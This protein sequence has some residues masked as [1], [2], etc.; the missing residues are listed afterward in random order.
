MSEDNGNGGAA[1]ATG[2]GDGAGT[3]AQP[4]LIV[5]AQYIKDFSFEAPGTP[6]VFS[7]MQQAQPDISVNVDVQARALE[8][9]V[10][11]VVLNVRADCKVGETQ[12]FLVEL[13]YGG[14]FTLNVAQDNVHPVLLI[15]C[16]RLLFPFAR[17][18]LATTTVNGGF[19]PLMLGPIDFASLYQRQARDA[20]AGAS[21]PPTPSA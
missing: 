4:P 1:T 21:P 11:E 10:Y 9:P 18:I 7:Q 14:V 8:A 13:S 17:Q 12:A 15:E 3:G 6:Q 19:L 2:N 16:P 20:E 5:N